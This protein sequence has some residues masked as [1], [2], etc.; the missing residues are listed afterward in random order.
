MPE[1]LFVPIPHLGR[2]L[3]RVE[4][5]GAAHIDAALEA[6]ACAEVLREVG[7]RPFEPLPAE[8]GSVRQEVEALE[9]QNPLVSY[10]TIQQ[11]QCEL[12]SAV[13]SHSN[14]IPAL[15]G[16]WPNDVS[17]QWYRPGADVGIT[18]HRD[19]KHYILLVTIFT[20]QGRARFGLHPAR[21]AEAV[22]SWVAAP[23]GLTLL[24]GPGLRGPNDRPFH[25]VSPPLDA[26]P[27]YSLG[28]RMTEGRP[29]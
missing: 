22:V 24:R 28:F 9:L 1:R 27:R 16:W 11:L 12:G 29:R 8:V 25:S 15:A 5:E 17:V 21:T 10:P 7:N 6:E 13:R 2:S 18:P 4:S 20:L 14:V 19:G 23:G 26:T 3:R